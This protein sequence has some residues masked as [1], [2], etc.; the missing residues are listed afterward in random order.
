M[1]GDD[2]DIDLQIEVTVKEGDSSTER[3]KL[4][5]GLVKRVLLALQYEH[6]RTTVRVNGCELDVVAQDKQTGSQVFVECK[7]YRDKTISAEVL[8]KLMGNLAFHEEYKAAWLVTTGRLGKDAAGLVEQH[9]A[10][11]SE[12]RERLRV[13]EP[14]QLIELL[15]STRQVVP[16]ES[17]KLPPSHLVLGSFTLCIT[18]LGEFWAVSAIGPKSGV[19][20]TVLAFHAKDG[21]PVRNAAVLQELASRDSNLKSLQWVSGGDEYLAIGTVADTSLRQELDNIAPVPI[22]DDWSDYRPARVQDFV[23]R[24]ELLK[25]ITRYF[26]DVRTGQ[27]STRLLA[28]KA[29]SGWGKSSFLVKLRSVCQQGRNKERVFLYAVDCRTASS[30]RYPELAMKRCIDEAIASGFLT[31]GTI[32]CRVPSAGQPFTDASMQSVLKELRDKNRLIVL[33]FDQFEEITTKQELADLFV[34]IKMLCA[35]VESAEENIVLGF[36]WKTDGSIPTDHPAYHVWHS[37]ADRR[38]EFELPL[39]SKSDISKLLGRLSRE[40]NAPI[41]HGLRRLLGEHC[42]GYPWLLKKLC[43]HVFQVLQSK[44]AAQRE[45]LDRAL[46]VEAL[47]RKD[48]ADLDHVQIACLER[49]ASDSPADHFK[50]VEQFGD[51]TVDSLIH[52]RLIVRNAGKLVLYWDIFRD[53]VLSKQVPAIPAR[54][55][56]VSTPTTARLVIEACATSSLIPKLCSK[57]TLQKGTLDN[58]ARDLV[59]MGV[60]SYD[61]KNERL[62]LLHSNVRDSLAAAFKF[63][64]SHALLRRAVEAHGKGFRQVPLATLISLWSHEFSATEYSDSTISAIARRMVLWFQ[65]LAILTVDSSDLVS[66]RVDQSAPTDFSQFRAEGRR[67]RG[68]RLFL[69]EAP[70]SRV[71]DVVKRLRE[72]TYIIEPSDRNALYALNRLRLVSSTINPVLLDRPR[73]GNEEA[74]LALKALAQP[75]VRVALELKGKDPEVGALEVGQAFETRFQMGVSEASMRR[76]GSGVL[77]WIKWLEDMDLVTFKGKSDVHSVTAAEA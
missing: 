38:R 42:Q 77:V 26:E 67:R 4:L 72:P 35:A 55:V 69:G 3:G 50:V 27:S 53:F 48:L 44:P 54:Y 73:K 68:R 6:V 66:H 23:G 13:W 8:T 36:S 45:L 37:F 7:A 15:V 65:S 20:D 16:A 1:G 33:F 64:G 5:E 57:L 24:D 31:G 29:P 9:K 61:R 12:K 49:I 2:V 60:C 51:H 52:R 30:P 40:V 18:D 58:V 32:Q 71:L 76:Y 21:T 75:T 41:E 56:P 59:M 17:L 28:I 10:K 70:P 22:A 46:D 43:V 39:F 47:F 74:W 14:T 25:D 62:K 11:T 34:Q 63:F 19:A